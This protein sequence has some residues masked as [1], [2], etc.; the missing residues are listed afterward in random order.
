MIAAAAGEF[1]HTREAYASLLMTRQIR[2]VVN[3]RS[4]KFATKFDA[5][6]RGMRSCD[7][8]D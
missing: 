5:N 2:L 6:G 3:R 7:D 4:V 8:R 1:A